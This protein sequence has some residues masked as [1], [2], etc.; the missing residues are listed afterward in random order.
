MGEPDQ[1][2]GFWYDGTFVGIFDKSGNPQYLTVAGQ[3]SQFAAACQAMCTNV[4]VLATDWQGQPVPAGTKVIASTF[5][6]AFRA[7]DSTARPRSRCNPRT[8]VMAIVRDRRQLRAT[9]D[10]YHRV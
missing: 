10:R 1:L 6:I 7:S 4:A 9:G 3:T 8:P 2:P 5:P